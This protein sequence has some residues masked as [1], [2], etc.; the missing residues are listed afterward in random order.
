MTSKKKGIYSGHMHRYKIG[1]VITCTIKG[2]GYEKYMIEVV[3]RGT[4]TRGWVESEKNWIQ[5][6]AP[7]QL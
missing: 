2:M 7:E 4:G 1:S 3:G 6:A 5:T